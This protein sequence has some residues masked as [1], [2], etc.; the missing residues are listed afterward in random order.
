[1]I[2]AAFTLGAIDR[3]EAIK[4]AHD[5]YDDLD[6]AV[7]FVDAC[8]A[9]KELTELKEAVASVRARFIGG[10][11]DEDD[12]K[13]LLAQI[14]ITKDATDRYLRRWKIRLEGTDRALT[15]SQLC[16]Y[17]GA[18]VI[19]SGE[20]KD[21][22]RTMKYSDADSNRIVRFCLIGEAARTSKEKAK[23]DAAA[24]REIQRRL[25]EDEKQSKELER[26]QKQ[27]ISVFLATRTEANMKAWWKAHE[28][29]RDEILAT[30]LLKG[31]SNADA[32]RWLETNDPTHA[33]SGNRN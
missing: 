20:M 17:H 11:I 22:L 29:S 8:Q 7:R 32:Q 33:G 5:V 30:L 13:R 28:I 1:M 21:R 31:Y 14:G 9:D 26:I 10:R 12:V 24:R 15:A 3:G 4:E 25:K 6:K 18:G 16:H 27:R 23:Q 2:C 19:T